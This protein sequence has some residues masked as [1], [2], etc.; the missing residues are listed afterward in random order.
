MKISL[1]GRGVRARLYRRRPA[2]GSVATGAALLF[3]NTLIGATLGVVFWTLAAHTYDLAAVGL[4]SATIGSALLV[5][6]LTNLG[7]TAMV[8]RYLPV[9][10]RAGVGLCRLALILPGLLALGIAPLLGFVPGLGGLIRALPAT[11]PAIG[12][13]LALL[14]A[15]TVIGLV[16]DSIAVARGQAGAVLLRGVSAALVRLGLLWP[17][18]TWGATGLL[19]AYTAGA[20]VALVLGLMVGRT[21]AG[22]AT[23]PAPALRQM[24]GY[25]ATSY[26]SGLCSQAPQLLYPVIIAT[27]VSATAAGAF[28]YAWM[29]AALL[30][31]LPPVVANVVLADLVRT[32]GAAE[33]RLR[34]ATRTVTLLTAGLAA[35][36]G[37]AVWLVAPLVVPQGAE[38]LRSDLPILLGSIVLYA[39][40]RFQTMSFAYAEQFGRLLVLN[41]TVAAAAVVLPLLLVAH[42]GVLG[43]EAGWLGSQAL[44]VGLGRVLAGPTPV[45]IAAPA[46]GVAL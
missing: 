12:T 45:R 25:S 14:A 17:A 18:A 32:S 31:A 13:L 27:Q 23:G 3:A 11:T 21:P 35:A 20:L 4:A 5:A 30:M 9:A 42:W 33:A 8:I 24:A 43:L 36:L 46:Q 39:V 15:A 44:G 1:P 2:R 34:A 26:L 22:A 38:A 40:V 6:T 41:A 37:I 10:G 29:A 19:A 28:A 16:Q 7:L